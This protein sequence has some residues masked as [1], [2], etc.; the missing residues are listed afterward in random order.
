MWRICHARLCSS[1]YHIK[2][3]FRLRFLWRWFHRRCLPHMCSC[4]L[5]H[6]VRPGVCRTTGGSKTAKAGKARDQ[7]NAKTPESVSLKI[8]GEDR[9]VKHLTCDISISHPP[10]KPPNESET[11]A[12]LCQAMHSYALRLQHSGRSEG[13][14]GRFERCNAQEEAAAPFGASLGEAGVGVVEWRGFI[15]LR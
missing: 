11:L 5:N 7:G 15:R 8:S 12:K 4:F 13:V 6:H 2:T 9:K 1:P 10:F 14:L 3:M